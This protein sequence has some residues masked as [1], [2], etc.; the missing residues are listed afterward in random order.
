MSK[1]AE[2]SEEMITP[3]S[4]Q[5]ERYESRINR[6]I[7]LIDENIGS[8]LSLKA[9][10]TSACLA[11]H[12]FHRIF[13]SLVGETVHD[14]TTRLRLE[15]AVSLARQKPK[16]SWKQIAHRCGY[17]SLPVFS[18][19]FRR[20]FG[21]SPAAFDLATYW[22][23]RPDADDARRV[24]RYFLRPSPSVPKNFAV[25]IVR[26][27]ETRL[28]V[29]RAVG[30]YVRPAALLEAYERLATWAKR[31]RLPMDGGRLA[32]T[33]RDD[34]EMTPLSRC[35]YNFTLEIGANVT[36]PDGLGV[37]TRR[38]GN[39]ARHH[40]VGDMAAVDRAWNLMFKSWLP[41]AGLQL[42]NEAAAEVYQRV[43]ARL[44]GR[45]FDLWCCVPV[46]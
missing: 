11:P 33:S 39:W 19:A 1:V 10:A 3:A 43:P 31:A 37:A 38:E 15:R 42:R 28:A 36:P 13:R 41:A 32:G 18:R 17:R 26:W 22:S 30:G 5:N 20:H 24:S 29:S 40:V 16:L 8:D 23:S 21:T 45:R 6:A 27:P 25:E 4:N 12:H 44:D 2:K 46:A 7:A 34:P 9:L 14:F 35:R